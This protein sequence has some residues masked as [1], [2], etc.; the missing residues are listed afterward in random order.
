MI[1]TITRTIDSASLPDEFHTIVYSFSDNRKRCR[2]SL[3]GFISYADVTALIAALE[4]FCENRLEPFIEAARTMPG[5]VEEI[6]RIGREMLKTLDNTETDDDF[7][8]RY[9]MKTIADMCDVDDFVPR[10]EY[11]WSDL[12]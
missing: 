1:V 4:S 12:V 2:G 9:T 6:N 7:F 8:P 5:G 11:D 3:N 10:D